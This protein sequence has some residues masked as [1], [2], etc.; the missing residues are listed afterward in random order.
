MLG[1]ARKSATHRQKC[2]IARLVDELARHGSRDWLDLRHPLRRVGEKGEGRFE[3]ISWDEALDFLA[4]RLCAI[5]TPPA[6]L[7]GLSK[8]PRAAQAT[9]APCLSRAIP[10]A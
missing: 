2:D 5:P 4:A 10:G 1:F 7:P 6:R 9:A 3:R 8:R